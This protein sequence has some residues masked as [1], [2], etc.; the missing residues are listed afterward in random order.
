MP[1]SVLDNVPPDPQVHPE[2]EALAELATG[3]PEASGAAYDAIA[4]DV[5]EFEA[6]SGASWPKALTALDA[7]DASVARHLG[8]D[9]IDRARVLSKLALRFLTGS[10]AHGLPVMLR[11]QRAIL[12]RRLVSALTSSGLT[13]DRE[14]SMRCVFLSVGAWLAAGAQD[15]SMN[16]HV[17]L[18][19]VLRGALK[20]RSLEP[21]RRFF[22]EAAHGRCFGIHTDS[23]YTEEFN[24]E[25]W[26]RVYLAVAELCERD[27]TVRGLVASSWF[28]DPSIVRV[29]PHLAYLQQE[30]LD[31]G[32]FRFEAGSAPIHVERATRTSKSRKAL[33]D[34]G[35]YL[36][37]AYTIVWPRS[38]IIDWSRRFSR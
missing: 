13:E 35:Q 32:A 15:I 8:E 2:L 27:P 20:A 7:F 12:A 16:A 9:S 23:D 4:Q 34:A 11:P 26:R 28:Y 10:E 25:G 19:S 22:A 24:E 29:S 6:R 21:V 38:A 17:G 31:G 14:R 1:D 30:P 5:R 3:A 18:G 33:Y 36:P 37:S